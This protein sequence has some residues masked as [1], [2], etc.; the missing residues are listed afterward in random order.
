VNIQLEKHDDLN[1]T[2]IIALGKSD[3]QEKVEKEVKRIQKTANIKGFRLGKAPMG[4]VQKLY[5]KGIL[6]D[7]IQRMASDAMNNYIEENKLDILGYPIASNK[8]ESEI[9]IDGSEDFT[10][11]FDCGLAPQFT[12][13]VSKKKLRTT[14][15]TL[16]SVMAKWLISKPRKRKILS[17]QMSMS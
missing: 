2:V 3:Y 14:S 12:L 11:A 16:E 10:F 13:S 15:I 5:G 8:V 9:D 1:L 6:A 4:M 7:E 17:M